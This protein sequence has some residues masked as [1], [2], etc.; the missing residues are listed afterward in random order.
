MMQ[1]PE[2]YARFHLMRL[3]P[4]RRIDIPSE[5][6]CD[7]LADQV[8]KSN[9]EIN[10]EV[11]KKATKVTFSWARSTQFLLPPPHCNSRLLILRL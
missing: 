7:S 11:S 10:R 9:S 2:K 5:V 6:E 8:T 3:A 1:Q 4:L